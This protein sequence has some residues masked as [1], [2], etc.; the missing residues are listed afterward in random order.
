MAKILSPMPGYRISEYVL[1]LQPH[2][3]LRNRIMKVKEEFAE[4]YQAFAAARSK[5]H[6]T[7]VRFNAWNMA[8]ERLL[9]RLRDIAMGVT[10]FRV[11]LK[12]YG[13]FPSHTIYIEVSTKVSV[14]KLVKELRP[15]QR[16]MKADPAVTPHFI[17]EPHLTIARK[18]LPWQFE[19]GWLE[20]AH[21]HF[22]G[23]MV[24]DSML[25]L[26]RPAGAPGAYQI[27]ERL[28]F[29]DMPVTT[30]QGELFV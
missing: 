24:A 6:I 2:E 13:A 3:E 16:L 4:K 9:Y 28:E 1:L 30:R 19:K 14:Q 15:V 5:P 25:L 22:S 26:R 21:L 18:L 23:R 20:Y 11:E 12:D 17:T 29:R 7:L 8:E 10:P 27:V